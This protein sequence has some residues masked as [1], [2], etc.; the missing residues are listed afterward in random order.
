[1]LVIPV[2]KLHDKTD[3][4]F[5]LKPFIPE[6]DGQ[7][8]SD[9]LGAHR[10]DHYIFFLITKGVG[11]AIVDFE[12]KIIVANQLYFILPEQ[13]HYRIKTTEVKGWFIAVDPSLIDPV[14]RSAFESWSGFQDPVTLTPYD[15]G[16][17]DQLLNITYSKMIRHQRGGPPAFFAHFVNQ[18][19]N[20]RVAFQYRCVVGFYAGINNKRAG[21]APVLM[22]GKAAY[23]INIMRWVAAGK[24]YPNKVVDIGGCKSGIITKHHKAGR[25]VRLLPPSGDIQ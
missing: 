25:R 10:D 19:F 15:I 1:M 8:R 16:D 3:I 9:E 12:E 2:H 17:M 22:L 4:G 14:C 6:D 20:F 13:I 24:G 11:S 21:T 7:K 23:A 5:E 18:L